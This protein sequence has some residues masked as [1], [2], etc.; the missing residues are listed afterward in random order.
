[1]SLEEQVLAALSTVYDPELDEPITELGFVAT[2]AVSDHG[3]VELHLRLPTP[4]CAPNF[5][6]LMV[7]DAQKAVRG[8]PAVGE[9][10]V[11]LDGHYTGA[12]IN[13]AVAERS[14][15]TGVFTGE[16]SGEL[17]ALRELFQRKA[18]VGRQARVCNR[19][20]ANG[21]D[22]QAIVTTRLGELPAT[23]DAQ[24]CRSLR[25]SLGLSCD[26]RAPGIVDGH[27]QPIEPADLARWLRR[28]QLM[29]LSLE[30]NGELCRS[31]LDVRYGTQ[32][33]AQAAAA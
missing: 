24:R 30:T 31:L 19:L 20:R 14:G 9:L 10:A 32:L 13:R 17:G 5:A 8:I 22:D 3:D 2:C 16:P 28:A 27:G 23:I 21:L 11:V 18:L 26:D 33:P 12:E 1:M 15:F 4:Q 7:S 25:H 6:Y 29:S